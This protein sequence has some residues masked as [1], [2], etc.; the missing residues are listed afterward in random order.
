MDERALKVL[1]VDDDDVDREALE[2]GLRETGVPFQLMAARDGLE[3]LRL[4]RS[5][6][7]RLT[8]PYV[9]VLDLNMPRMGGIEFLGQ[10]REDPALADTVVF[11]LTTSMSEDD[12]SRAYGHQV[13]GYIAKTVIGS[14]FRQLADMLQLYWRL[15]VLPV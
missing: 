13:A 4:L 14:D 11:V 7:R 9:I 6:G 12:R 2:R 10:L 5:G 15:V 3:A 1:H 8:R